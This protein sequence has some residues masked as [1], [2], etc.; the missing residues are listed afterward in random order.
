MPNPEPSIFYPKPKNLRL[1]NV[2]SL[3]WTTFTSSPNQSERGAIYSVLQHKVWNNWRIRIHG[4]KT[5]VWYQSGLQ[6]D[7]CGASQRVA[8]ALD[9]TVRVWRGWNCP[10]LNRASRCWDPPPVIQSLLPRIWSA[11]K[12]STRNAHGC[13]CCT[14]HLLT[15]RS[16]C[17]Q[18]ALSSSAHSLQLKIRVCGSV[19]VRS[20]KYPDLCDNN[21]RATASLPLTLGRLGLRS[22]LR[23]SHPT[24]ASW[25]TPHDQRPAPSGRS[26]D[27]AEL[28]RRTHDSHPQV[29]VRSSQTSGGVPSWRALAD[30]FR[31]PPHDPEDHEPGTVRRVFSTGL[32][33]TNGAGA[34]A[35]RTRRWHVSLDNANVAS[36]PQGVPL[37]S[38]SPLPPPSSAH[39]SVQTPLPVW[40]SNRCIWP[41]PCS[42]QVFLGGGGFALES[43]AARFAAKE[44]PEPP[45]TLWCTIRNPECPTSPM[46]AILKL[47]QTA[48]P[49]LGEP[50]WRWIPH[51]F[52]SPV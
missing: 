2:R 41:A 17:V 6:S 36:D 33:T 29:C 48:F 26:A 43:V 16:S 40:P 21:A 38:S 13:C 12:Q 51:W 11:L 25:L 34:I 49:S 37:V 27:R 31:P 46:D 4:G 22:A 20:C 39:F 14:L 45:P 30:G 24:L 3:S 42:L 23:T 28:A 19:S 35:K 9:P 8:E 47:W 52:S 15:P 1:A 7:A 10:M 18:C 5:H 44:E 32:Q 50:S